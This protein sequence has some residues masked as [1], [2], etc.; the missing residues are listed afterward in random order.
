MTA[1]RNRILG[2]EHIPARELVGA[3]WNWRELGRGQRAALAASLEELGIYDALKVRALPDG[4]R[5]M[6]DG[7]KRQDLILAD[8]GPETLIP[9]LVSDLDEQEARQANLTHDPIG[10]MAKTNAE[11]RASLLSSL[12][13]AR[14]AGMQALL[15]GMAQ[16]AEARQAKVAETEKSAAPMVVSPRRESI[17]AAR[18]HPL[19][20]VLDL[21]YFRRWNALKEEY[22]VKSDRRALELVLDRMDEVGAEESIE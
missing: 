1:L 5:E 14:T 8:I 22:G 2:L 9:C 4:R 11:K 12:T 16:R 13:Q 20:I 19:A 18:R 6:I 10:A 15:D 7:H 17:P 21:E 3:P